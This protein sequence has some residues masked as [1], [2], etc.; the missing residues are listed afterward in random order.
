MDAAKHYAEQFAARKVLGDGGGD[1]KTASRS[2]AEL[3]AGKLGLGES[4]FATR[5]IADI[6]AD[7]D[8]IKVVEECQQEGWSNT[9][10]EK[11]MDSLCGKIADHLIENRTGITAE[12]GAALTGGEAALKEIGTLIKAA[13]S[14]SKIL[15]N[16]MEGDSKAVARELFN[17]ATDNTG[18]A[19]KALKYTLQGMQNALDVWRDGEVENA[20][21]V[22][23]K[24]SSGSFCGYGEIK[25]LDFEAVWDGMKGASRQ[26]CIERIAAE[27]DAREL[28]GMPVLSAKEEDFYREKVKAEL[29]TEFERRV[30]LQS[31][32]DAEKENLELI[33]DE[34]DKANLL[35][36]STV[37]Y[38]GFGGAG[39][40]LENR[41]AR[42]EHLI[43]QI[44]R[45]LNVSDVYAGPQQEGD[46]NGRISA[47]AMAVMVRGYFAADTEAE[48]K[49]FLQDY[50]KR[51]GVNL[52]LT[53]EDLAGTYDAIWTVSLGGKTAS[54]TFSAL[55]TVSGDTVS[56][57]FI[58]EN[59]VTC[60]GTFADGTVKGPFEGSGGSGEFVFQFTRSDE[61]ITGQGTLT[62][63]GD[64]SLWSGT[65]TYTFTFTKTD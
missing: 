49:K 26:L 58:D 9:G 62:L 35:D 27:N 61:A 4:E 31:R 29:K 14:G 54:S 1:A 40:T 21:D 28:I 50:Y 23:T 2:V 43:Q 17:V 55:C 63:T 37:W 57:Q 3:I 13:D 42:M 36:S 44:Y 48:A 22:Y 45:D 7:Q 65:I 25:P 34:L 46:L 12:G 38:R 16:L 39:E 59:T 5:M 6:A 52:A 47:A 32:I 60:T 41:M 18:A 33:F 51:L 64:G 20:Y 8:V 15:A 24:G 19:G 56:F 11:V 10:Y 30:K 53:A